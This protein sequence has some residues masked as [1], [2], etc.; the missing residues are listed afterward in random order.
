MTTVIVTGAGG[1]I[2]TAVAQKLAMEGYSLALI[3][4]NAESVGSVTS[5]LRREGFAAESY[6]ADLS[7]EHQVDATLE[8]VFRAHDDVSGLFANAGYVK[9]GSFLSTDVDSWE[10]HVSVNLS[11][12][13][14]VCQHFA[15]RANYSR[16]AGVSIVVNAS[17]AASQYSRDLF[18][19][20]VTKAALVMMVKAIATELGDRGVR[21]NA[22]LPGVIE[23]HMTSSA[24]SSGD[25][26]ARLESRTPLR[27]LGQPEEVADL[28]AFLLSEQSGF[29]TGAA[30]PID[31]GQTLVGEPQWL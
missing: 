29:I 23:T 20:S 10:R 1:S 28:T 17:S 5:A 21:A 11:G 19:Y 25:L 24:L 12:T 9:F 13:F 31:G 2:G 30:I 15:R 4:R 16:G 14:L 27:R 26:R 22:I 3:D 6:V 7:D 18:A 8:S